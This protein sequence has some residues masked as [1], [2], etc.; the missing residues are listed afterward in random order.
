MVGLHDFF[1]TFYFIYKENFYFL[2]YKENASF[3]TGVNK[4][5]INIY[6]RNSI[7]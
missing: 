2:I 7:M 6:L 3:M 1:C 5:L 4:R